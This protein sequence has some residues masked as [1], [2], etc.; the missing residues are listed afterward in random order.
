MKTSTAL[1]VAVDLIVA[2]YLWQLIK[3]GAPD[4]EEAFQR[5]FFQCIAVL[6]CWWRSNAL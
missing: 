1:G 5:S 3:P 4:W 6:L 2:N